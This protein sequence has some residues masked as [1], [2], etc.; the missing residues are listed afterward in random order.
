M[1]ALTGC[2]TTGGQGDSDP[3]QGANRAVFGFNEVVDRYFLEPVSKGYAKVTPDPIQT[4]I[5]N[6]LENL[7]YLNVILNGVLQGKFGQAGEDLGRNDR[8][9]GSRDAL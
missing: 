5:Y 9:D 4:M 3:L 8:R 1:V 2:A 7:F 6:F